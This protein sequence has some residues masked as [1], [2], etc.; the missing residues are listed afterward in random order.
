M[1]DLS[2]DSV[3]FNDQLLIDHKT[4]TITGFLESIKHKKNFGFLILRS[5]PQTIQCIFSKDI[6]KEKYEQFTNLNQES[7]LRLTGYPKKLT[8]PIKATTIKFY[9]LEI[10]DLKIESSAEKLPFD[11]KDLNN[12]ILKI[13]IKK[14]NK[15]SG[16]AQIQE[17]R[18][19]GDENNLQPD[20]SMKTRLDNRTVDLR[21][22]PSSCIIR[23]LDETMFL[24]RSYLRQHS[25]MEMKTPK[26]LESGTEGGANLFEVKYFKKTAYLAQSPQFYK[27]M[28]IISGF[29]KVYEIGHVYRQEE[30]NINRYLSEFIG[31]DLEMETD[32]MDT[33]I[34][35]IYNL[36]FY[37]FKNIE[38]LEEF[39][40]LKK[41]FPF[42]NLVLSEQPYIIKHSEC[43]KLLKENG[44]EINYTDDLSRGQEKALGDIIKQNKNVDFFIIKE[45]PK[46]VRAFYTET[47][48][49]SFSEN[50]TKYVDKKS[51]DKKSTDQIS[52][53]KI[54][55]NQIS[56]DKISEIEVDPI[57]EIEY[58]KSFDGILRSEEIFSGSIR[59]HD[60]DR[61][62][63]SA[64]DLNINPENISSYLNCFKFGVPRHG[65][66]GVGLERLVKAMVGGKDIRLFTAFCR[67]PGRLGP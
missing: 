4:I 46:K 42:E 30:S 1:D 13:E 37:I 22:I 50:D 23:L 12:N 67:D 45:Y 19:E 43:V 63:Q 49:E 10:T 15:K 24:F 61:L 57:S 7:F 31:L 51:F 65:G 60:H 58:S 39:E 16:S 20:V 44:H 40:T 33:L 28:M 5:F 38:L 6:L 52:D 55:D 27:Q 21:S 17:Q 8:K 9:E 48:K 11:L 3:S 59:I 66:C 25:F 64:I 14:E 2:I 54:S 34:H 62:K 41:Y 47:L 29:K 26:L 36:F 18:D 35:F 53:D 56:D 32:S